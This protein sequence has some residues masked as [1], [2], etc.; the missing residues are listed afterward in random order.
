MANLLSIS[1]FIFGIILIIVGLILWAVQQEVEWYT[2]VL[3]IVGVV[4][5]LVGAVW[6]ILSP[7]GPKKPKILQQINDLPSNCLQ[8]NQQCYK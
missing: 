4:M 2:W 1:M 8:Q 5:A 7:H 6:W 3:W